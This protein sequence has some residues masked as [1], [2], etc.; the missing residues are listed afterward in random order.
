MPISEK[1]VTQRLEEYIRNWI[2]ELEPK[3][4]ATGPVVENT[5]VSL[6]VIS[7]NKVTLKIGAGYLDRETQSLV[8][9]ET[10]FP[11]ASITKSFTAAALLKALQSVRQSG[12]DISV[13]EV[14]PK[15]KLSSEKVTNDANYVDLL[16][17]RTGFPRH[18]SLWARAYLEADEIYRRFPSL[19][20]NPIDGSGFGET[21]QYNNLLYGL[22]GK[23]V[24]TLTGRDWHEYI[25]T[26]F[27]KPLKMVGTWSEFVRVPGKCTLAKPYFRNRRSQFFERWTVAPAA[28]MFSTA[29]S[30]AH[31][32]IFQMNRGNHDGDQIIPEDYFDN[33]LWNPWNDARGSPESSH[34]FSM[35]S[36]GLGWFVDNFLG[37]RL[38]HHI[39]SI[40]GLSAMASFMPERK[41]GVVVL[42]N[43]VQSELPKLLTKA[44][45]GHLLGA[46]KLPEEQFQ[47]PSIFSPETIMPVFEEG[48]VLPDTTPGVH[49]PNSALWTYRHP[50]YGELSVSKKGD[51]LEFKYGHEQ[52]LA[53]AISDCEAIA[54]TL[55]I[56]M[57][58]RMRILRDGSKIEIPFNFYPGNSRTVFGKLG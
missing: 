38:I 11:I 44:I 54:E 26:E 55:L 47:L 31:W 21:F 50:G 52:W 36:Y 39:G 18:D 58:A 22:C 6:A 43:Q 4:F 19:E 24:T 27:L 48:P 5:G 14:D 29:E 32:L 13:R 34:S 45:L 1:S 12:P 53:T 40:N 49:W 16:S 9:P 35:T 23:S 37:D 8:T 41:V 57:P 56:G 20:M 3:Q 30:L 7:D 46:T 2:K 42:V 51:H 25:E 10:V 28:S 15:F 33:W 17:H